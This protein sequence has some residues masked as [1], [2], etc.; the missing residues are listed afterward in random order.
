MFVVSFSITDRTKGT[1]K[2]RPQARE[3]EEK[4]KSNFA[5][6][7]NEPIMVSLAYFSTTDA[8]CNIMNSSVASRPA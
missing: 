2:K 8:S 7:F 5:Q 1:N 4:N 6:A 3:G